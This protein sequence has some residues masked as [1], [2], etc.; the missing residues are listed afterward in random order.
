MINFILP[1]F[2]YNFNLNLYLQDLFKLHPEYFNFPKMKIF[3]HEGNFPF[4][5]WS[6][7]NYNQFSEWPTLDSFQSILNNSGFQLPL[8]LDFS[9]TKLLKTDYLDCKLNGLIDFFSNGSNTIIISDPE[10]GKYLKNTYP[11]YPLIG[12]ENYYLKDQD[13]K[14]LNS[15]K[16]IKCNNLNVDNLYFQDITKSQIIIN[17]PI[18]C[19][20]CKEKQYQTCQDL[21]SVEN[22]MFIRD[23]KLLK[24]LNI[25]TPNY[26]NLINEI[27]SF[28]KK[29]YS[30][31]SF[32]FPIN[33]D[34]LEFYLKL[35]IKPEFYYQIKLQ[36]IQ[37]VRNNG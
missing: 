32:S 20:E 19:L 7:K 15:L 27:N 4:C 5:F 35:F 3:A 22:L 28:N 17:F 25:K 29:G 24:C 6:G 1:D 11:Y 9:N 8:F 34:Y 26:N 16:F 31:F 30:H 21:Y 33:F 36:V 13:K 37:E 18:G 2:Y 14:F 12:S 10:F 23:S